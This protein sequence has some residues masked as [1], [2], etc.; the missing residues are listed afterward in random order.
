MNYRRH[1]LKV[2][3][4]YHR[5]DILPEVKAGLNDWGRARRARRDVRAG[6]ERRN[7]TQDKVLQHNR[8][9][10]HRDGGGN[11]SGWTLLGLER[12]NLSQAA[13]DTDGHS[14][15]GRYCVNG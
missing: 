8:G 9:R 13:F 3:A 11:A 6:L 1:T 14:H 4:T 15:G 7:V 10:K 2:T 5:Q 12:R